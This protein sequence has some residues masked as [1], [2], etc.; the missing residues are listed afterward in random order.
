[1][2]IYIYIS[3][4]VGVLAGP[5]PVCSPAKVPCLQEGRLELLREDVVNKIYG[6]CPTPCSQLIYERSLSSAFIAN[7]L[8]QVWQQLTNESRSYLNDN[9]AKVDLFFSDLSYT[10]ITSLESYPVLSLFCDIGGAMGLILGSTFLTAAEFLEFFF[11]NVLF[12][13]FGRGNN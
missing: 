12:F 9:Y 5:Y 2:Y 4:W 13:L 3:V 10:K 1:M 7:H 6:G 11:G 8:A